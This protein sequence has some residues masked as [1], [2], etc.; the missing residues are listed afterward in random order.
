MVIAPA[1]AAMAL[2]VTVTAAFFLFTVR[3]KFH[4]F[5]TAAGWTAYF[6]AVLSALG[7]RGFL[8]ALPAIIAFESSFPRAMASSLKDNTVP[9]D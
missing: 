4:L 6:T 5:K 8:P 7:A 2:P 9:F 3:T 1:A